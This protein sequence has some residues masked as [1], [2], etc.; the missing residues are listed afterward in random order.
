[1]KSS[2]QSLVRRATLVRTFAITAGLGMAAAWADEASDIRVG[3][4]LAAKVC[5][6]C[7]AV[8]GPPGLS[9]AEIAKGTHAAPDALRALLTSTQSDVSHPYAMPNPELTERQI[10]E[11]SAYLDSLRGAK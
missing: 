1:M 4:D 3:Q 9:F 5:S 10:D 11:I 8:A 2:I 6:P 7:H